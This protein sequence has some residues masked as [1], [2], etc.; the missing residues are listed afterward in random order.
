MK[1]TNEN[2][3]ISGYGGKLGCGM[4]DTRWDLEYESVENASS[5]PTRASTTTRLCS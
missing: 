3:K 5:T 1:L 4:R 2:M